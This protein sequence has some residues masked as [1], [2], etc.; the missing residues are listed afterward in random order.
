MPTIEYELRFPYLYEQSSQF[1]GLVVDLFRSEA[2]EDLVT[3]P[4]HLDTG[5]GC[6]LF[7]GELAIPIGLN[8]LEG[9]GFAFNFTSG[10]RLEAKRH[11]VVIAHPELGSFP[12]VMAFSIGEIRRNILGRDF[13]RLIQIGVRELHSELYVTPTP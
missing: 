5:A 7:D 8:L 12:L 3:L 11:A 2:P 13:L 6:S 1:P 9:E 4:A 10:A